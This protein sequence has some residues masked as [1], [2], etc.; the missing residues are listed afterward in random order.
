MG[1]RVLEKRDS[2]K[3]RDQKLEDE[4]QYKGGGSNSRGESTLVGTDSQRISTWQ[5]VEFAVRQLRGF[6]YSHGLGL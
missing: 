3:S 2:H 5:G 6:N 4:G 1:Y